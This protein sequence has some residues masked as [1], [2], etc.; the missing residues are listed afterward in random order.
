MLLQTLKGTGFN[1]HSSSLSP[2]HSTSRPPPEPMYDNIEEKR[3]VHAVN[4]QALPQIQPCPAYAVPPALPPGLHRSI[5]AN[6]Q[7]QYIE[8]D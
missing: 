5:V 8:F 7:Q 1:T 2:H 3:R 6:G 4:V